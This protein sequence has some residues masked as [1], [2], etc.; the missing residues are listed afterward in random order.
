MR[1]PCPH[2]CEGARDHHRHG[3]II[4]VREKRARIQLSS[5]R[6]EHS[7]MWGE[8]PGHS[9]NQQTFLGDPDPVPALAELLA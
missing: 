4:W 2:C 3:A 8:E 6:D 7:S 9:V 5:P 1:D